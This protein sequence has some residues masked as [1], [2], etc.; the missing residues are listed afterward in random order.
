[1]IF[2]DVR[3]I[4]VECSGDA[5]ARK[6]IVRIHHVNGWGGTTTDAVA[7]ATVIIESLSTRSEPVDAD[8]VCITLD[9][10]DAVADLEGGILRIMPRECY[11]GDEPLSSRAVHERTADDWEW[12]KPRE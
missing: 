4:E 2:E 8:H 9:R 11:C 5:D 3:S 12:S 6:G 10:H 7:A 1:M